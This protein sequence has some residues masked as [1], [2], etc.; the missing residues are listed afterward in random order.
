MLREKKVYANHCEVNYFELKGVVEY[1][2]KHSCSSCKG[3]HI[4]QKV[5]QM[6]T[7]YLGSNPA[8]DF[9]DDFRNPN[10][11][12]LDYEVT[13]LRWSEPPKV[14]RT[15]FYEEVPDEP[16]CKCHNCKVT[17]TS[18]GGKTEIEIEGVPV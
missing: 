16:P 10:G 5:N 17:V 2:V 1:D 6:G 18:Q 7:T 8:T 14:T 9:I 12:R 15:P 11:S 13:N 3:H 4:I